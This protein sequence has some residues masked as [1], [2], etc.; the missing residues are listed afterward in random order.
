MLSEALY[1]KDPYIKEWEAEV[2][3]VIEGKHIILDRTAFYPGGGGQPHDTGTI[4]SGGHAYNV[5]GLGKDG[6]KIIHEVDR[7]G[8]KEEERVKCSINWDRRYKLMRMHTAAHIIAQMFHM[9]TGALITGGQLG[10]EQSRIDMSIDVFGREKLT[11]YEDRVNNVIK[12]NLD[13]SF[14]Y[15]P[16]EEAMKDPALFKLA[17]GFPEHIREV[18]IVSIGGYDVQAD[19]GTHVRNTKEIG[20]VKFAGFQN[21]GKANRRIYYTLEQ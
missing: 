2:A 16:R 19:G 5:V 14:K 8:L 13:V 7:S 6:E 21:K 11:E 10:E 20:A 4:T 18:R 1:L 17:K 3:G 9:E 15:V 12:R